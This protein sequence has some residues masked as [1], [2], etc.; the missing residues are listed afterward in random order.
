MIG[1]IQTLLSL[2]RIE[3][4]SGAHVGGVVSCMA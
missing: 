3:T 1:R 4:A 2:P